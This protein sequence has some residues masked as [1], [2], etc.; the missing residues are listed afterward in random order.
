MGDIAELIDIVL[1]GQHPYVPL[2]FSSRRGGD[3]EGDELVSCE[4][5]RAAAGGEEIFGPIS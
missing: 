2:Q 1:T 5:Y 4:G 3:V